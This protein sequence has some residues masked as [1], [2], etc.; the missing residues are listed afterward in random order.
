MSAPLLFERHG[1]VAHLR[2]NRPEVLNAINPDL[3]GRLIDSIDEVEAA[4]SLNAI[5]I[6]GSGS[7]AF[8]SGADLA[9]IKEL[10]GMA[11]DAS[12]KGHGPRLID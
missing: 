3:C 9:T 7:R 4:P 10:T 5:V 1:A 2:L 8:C 12:S 11:N 6:S